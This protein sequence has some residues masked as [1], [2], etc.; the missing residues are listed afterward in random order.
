[1]N[2]QAYP[3]VE[4]HQ[5]LDCS[6][7]YQV[8]HAIDPTITEETYRH[9][10]VG[11]ARCTNL[12]D[13]LK[14]AP[15]CIA[16][17]QTP[18]HLRMVVD[19]VMDQLKRDNVLYAEIRFA[20]LLHTQQGMS[21]EEVVEVVN[22]ALTNAIT[23]TGVEARLILCILRH[24]HAEESM[25]TVHLVEQFRGTNVVGLDIAGDEAGY[26]LD[27]H[28]GAFEYAIEQG[29]FRTAH[30]GE[31]LGAESVWETLRYLEPT[32]IGHGARSI[33]DPTL[34]EKLRAEQIH[35]ELCPASNLQTNMYDTY[36]DHPINQLYQQGVSLSVNTDNRTITP[37]TLKQEYEHL[38]Q[39]FQWGKEHFLHCNLRALQASF[40]PEETKS[41]LIERLRTMYANCD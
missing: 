40:L 27:E 1:M 32:R 12:A 21:P 34:V 9:E 29:I 23:T 11:P 31:A 7:S 22:A 15:R 38:H 39:Y 4:L 14:R 37:V 33:E 3:K 17:M 10:F 5:H 26:P 2:I 16:L 25:Q 35:L 18:E 19:D 28:I 20:P 30:A 24:F 13:F 8:V 36:V 6:L 41:R